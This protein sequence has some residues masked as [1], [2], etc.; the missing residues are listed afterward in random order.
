MSD[1][2]TVDDGLRRAL[3]RKASKAADWIEASGNNFDR[4][5]Q[6]VSE[7]AGIAS[8]RVRCRKCGAEKTVD[9]A[10]CLAHG[11]PECHGETMRLLRAPE[12]EKR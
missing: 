10:H 2:R 5:Y 7:E 3:V 4:M 6:Q 1:T 12:E 9:G 11:W 8:A